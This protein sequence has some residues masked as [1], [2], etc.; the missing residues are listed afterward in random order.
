MTQYY[1]AHITMKGDP[2][3]IRQLVEDTNWKFSSI[4]GDINLGD[5]IKC[6]ATT[7]FNKK[8]GDEKIIDLLKGTA[9]FLKMRGVEILRRKVEIVIYDD[10][11]SKVGACLGEGCGVCHTEEEQRNELG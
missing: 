1:E 3:V 2:A 7:Q 11:S 10:R 6:Y 8:L 5:G 9:A 4:D